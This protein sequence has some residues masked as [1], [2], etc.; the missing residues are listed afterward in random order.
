MIPYIWEMLGSGSRIKLEL[1]QAI[2]R[3]RLYTVY[4]LNVGRSRLDTSLDN[5]KRILIVSGILTFRSS[6]L[7]RIFYGISQFGGDAIARSVFST[8]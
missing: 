7:I 1:L 6:S 8:K 5:N 2:A 3:N 4:M